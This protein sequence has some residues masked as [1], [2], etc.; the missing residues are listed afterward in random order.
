M[1]KAIAVVIL[2]ATATTGPIKPAAAVTDAEVSASVTGCYADREQL[3]AK[4]Q[5][6]EAELKTYQQVEVPPEPDQQTE[7]APV[8]GGQ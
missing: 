4:I 7:P 6:L 1:K 2:T 5:E 3:Q 8:V